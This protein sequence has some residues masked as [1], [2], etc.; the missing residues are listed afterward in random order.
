MSKITYTDK[1]TLNENPNVA[2]VNK[3]KAD[4]LNEIKNVVNANDDKFNYTQGEQRIGTW[5]NGKPLYRKVIKVTSID[6]SSNNYDVAISISNLNEIVNIGG[7]IKI[8]NTNTYKPITVIYTDNSNAIGSN[9]SFSV[10]AITNS[11]IS[12]SYG[13]WWK[14]IFDKAYIILEYTKTT[15]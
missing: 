3:V 6:R 15:D 7:T 4:D 11:Y 8:T 13:S 10:Y 12:L 2:D 1:V 9:Y 14:E 5:I